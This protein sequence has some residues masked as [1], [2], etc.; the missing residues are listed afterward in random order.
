MN[1]NQL[2]TL[3]PRRPKAKFAYTGH[4]PMEFVEQNL[5]AIKRIVKDNDLRRMYRGERC[6]KYAGFTLKDNAHSL[7]LYKKGY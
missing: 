7:V 1:L 4:I 3:Y 6:D 2:Q 5:E